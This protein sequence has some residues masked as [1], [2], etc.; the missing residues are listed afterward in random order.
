MGR[1]D[2]LLICFLCAINLFLQLFFL[3]VIAKYMVEQD[4]G[5][6][7]LKEFLDW[8]LR[9]A[10]SLKNWDELSNTSLAYRVCN[11]YGGNI[12]ANVQQSLKKDVSKFMQQDSIFLAGPWLAIVSIIVWS[13]TVLREVCKSYDF[14]IAL[15]SLLQSCRQR[16]KLRPTDEGRFILTSISCCR[17][18]FI[19]VL[20]VI[21]R[22]IICIWLFGVG[23]QYLGIATNTL[24]DLILN[25]VALG[26]ILELDELVYLAAP[27]RIRKVLENTEPVNLR[28]HVL[29]FRG[30]VDLRSLFVVAGVV[31]ACV[32]C[33][34]TAMA[35]KV[36]VMQELTRLLCDGDV[37]FL[38]VHEQGTGV[39]RIAPTRDNMD[40]MGEKRHF[41][42]AVLQHTQLDLLKGTLKAYAEYIPEEN[43]WS[44]ESLE[45][46]DVIAKK[47][48]KDNLEAQECRDMDADMSF[49]RALAYQFLGETPTGTTAPPFCS[50][51]KQNCSEPN[52]RKVCSETCRCSSVSLYN[53]T[54]CLQSC[55]DPVNQASLARGQSCTDVYYTDMRSI[56]DFNLFVSELRQSLMNIG[57]L[58]QSVGGLTFSQKVRNDVYR[59]SK[60]KYNL[61]KFS[62]YSKNFTRLI[63]LV[64]GELAGRTPCDMVPLY[65]KIFSVNLCGNL[66]IL[67]TLRGLCPQT[68]AYP[69]DCDSSAD[70]ST[71]EQLQDHQS[72]LGLTQAL[73]VFQPI[74]LCGKN[75]R[76]VSNTYV[77]FQTVAWSNSTYMVRWCASAQGVRK[78]TFLDLNFMSLNW[79]RQEG[80]LAI[81]DLPFKRDSSIGYVLVK[82]I[83]ASEATIS[84]ECM[85]DANIQCGSIVTGSTKG[86]AN[87]SGGTKGERVFA[88]E[89]FSER[90]TVTISTCGSPIDTVLRLY[91]YPSLGNTPVAVMSADSS[92]NCS[93][94]AEL[95]FRLPTIKYLAEYR[96][97]LKG[98][99]DSEGAYNLSLTCVMAAITCGQT[100][101]GT[102]EDEKHND[103]E[104]VFTTGPLTPSTV[105]PASWRQTCPCFKMVLSGVMI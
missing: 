18:I 35:S 96:L 66:G 26:F 53:R 46:L 71:W 5:E 102:F 70:F 32:F 94:K 24:P 4:L 31:G 6:D 69:K 78:A 79:S 12:I 17:F 60:N 104:Y 25:A 59:T 72:K 83:G 21:P 16:S 90:D 101:T 3:N 27:R 89:G 42:L 76:T 9:D 95:V 51:V 91:Q 85:T 56:T 52:I 38:Y 41:S 43:L 30:F 23:I 22:F 68:C 74:L 82:S 33:W 84:L 14:T 11:D 62:K 93:K 80:C 98:Q 50:R 37:N 67:G 54:G 61:T 47:T 86:D 81:V 63:P 15:L 100:I 48:A 7:N 10:H 73:A 65:N 49:R 64:Q 103:V 58:E 36:D 87:L 8:R 1:G 55:D 92:A 20:V 45:Q 19:L 77:A 44:P 29:P 2:T 99:N 97:L 75:A 57:L 39:V 34:Y 40:L 105:V 88:I 13:A 28:D